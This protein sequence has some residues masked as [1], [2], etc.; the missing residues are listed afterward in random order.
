MDYLIEV[1]NSIKKRRTE[2]GISQQELAEPVFVR[3][4]EIRYAYF[5]A[6]AGLMF[7]LET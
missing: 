5:Q 6:F 1:G 3:F 7:F 4:C 2:K